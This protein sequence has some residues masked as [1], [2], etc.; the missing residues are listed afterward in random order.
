[1]PVHCYAAPA[2]GRPLEP[3][4]YRPAPLGS[5]E[6][7]VEITH[8]GI[9]HSD[10]HLINDDWGISSYPLVPGHEIVGVVSRT[11]SAT[12]TLKA[13]DRVGIGWQRS[14]CGGCEWCL[15][16]HDNLCPD[17]EATCVGHYGGFAERIRCDSR[18]CFA[19]PAA[20]A[21]ENAAPLLCAGITVYSP[22][23]QHGITANM[24]V[25]V[26]GI[27]GLGH[28]ALQFARAMGCEVTAYSSSPGKKDE[29]RALGAERFVLVSDRNALK[30]AQGSQDFI[31]ST[32]CGDLDW[33]GLM[34]C[35][36]PNGRLCLVGVSSGDIRLSPDALIAGQKTICGSMI[37]GRARMEEMLEFSARRG[38]QARS[39]V[40][41][42][43]E[44]NRAIRKVAE[45][46]A[47]Y[48]MV[49]SNLQ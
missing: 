32:V 15:S 34:G 6:V 27:G 5:R 41:P 8:C 35:L 23:R 39:E 37:G 10:V 36:R 13:G 16:G 29:A 46:Q 3:F 12:E 19:L 38:I 20:L 30:R 2:A 22:L 49:L 43:A 25:G 18:Y 44:V 7:E 48:R 42:M 4:Q 40:L 47:R 28:L 9:C 26:V 17:S 11:G 14:A 21:P 1:M 24:R 45:N 33:A 31:L